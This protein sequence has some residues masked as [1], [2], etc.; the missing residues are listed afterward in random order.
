MVNQYGRRAI[1]ASVMPNPTNP[2]RNPINPIDEA[3]VAAAV[4]KGIQ[5]FE[6]SEAQRK[7]K[8]SRLEVNQ[9]VQL[10]VSSVIR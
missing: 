5:V 2:T 3:R 4:Q 1:G 9:L 10:G 6:E 8:E 7:A